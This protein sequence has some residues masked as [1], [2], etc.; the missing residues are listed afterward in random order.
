MPPTIEYEDSLVEVHKV[1]FGP[2]DN[3]VYVGRS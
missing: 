3:N 1:V 2:M